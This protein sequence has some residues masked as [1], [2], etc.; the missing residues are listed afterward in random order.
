MKEGS[1]DLA[2]FKESIDAETSDSERQSA[3]ARAL[4]AWVRLR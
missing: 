4:P 1:L 2:K 3:P